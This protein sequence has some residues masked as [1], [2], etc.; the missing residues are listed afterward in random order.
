MVPHFSL[1]FVF[2][3]QGVTLDDYVVVSK[4][5]H[6][7]AQNRFEGYETHVSGRSGD[8]RGWSNSN[9]VMLEIMARLFSGAWG[10]SMKRTHTYWTADSLYCEL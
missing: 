4:T 2:F 1:L 8:T 6:S 7:F 9:F 3:F 5:E 10:A